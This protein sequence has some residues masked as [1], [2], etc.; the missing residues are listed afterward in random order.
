MRWKEDTNQYRGLVTTDVLSSN[1]PEIPV[2]IADFCEVFL[3]YAVIYSKRNKI[4]A[5]SIIC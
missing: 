5:I 1:V 4:T 2:S 3:R